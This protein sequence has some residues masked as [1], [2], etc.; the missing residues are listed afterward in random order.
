MRFI[1]SAFAVLIIAFL[2]LPFFA[3]RVSAEKVDEYP[4]AKFIINQKT[5]HSADIINATGS[6]NANRTLANLQE[7]YEEAIEINEDFD[8]INIVVTN[9]ATIS[10]K[11]IDRIAA[12]ADQKDID[13]VLCADNME[14]K[15]VAS[16]LIIDVN[17]YEKT[18]KGLY[19]TSVLLTDSEIE[20]LLGKSAENNLTV[21][22]LTQTGNLAAPI[23]I[24]VKLDIEN[25]ETLDV[26]YSFDPKTN[27]YKAIRTSFAVD[28]NG[29]AHFDVTTGGYIVVAAMGVIE[30]PAPSTAE[31]TEISLSFTDFAVFDGIIYSNIS[32]ERSWVEAGY[33][34][35]KGEFFDEVQANSDNRIL[36]EIESGTANLMPVGTK[37]YKCTNHFDIILADTPDGMIP[38]LK[39]VEG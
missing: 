14:G 10:Y 37:F 13:V 21:L 34:Y 9:A 2:V 11:T 19:L 7:V 27:E 22:D 3:L 8:K 38:F 23:E 30:T 35:I 5:V 36:A 32:K 28:K 18:N 29:Y 4:L 24:A 25:P 1:L 26:Y 31:I 20:T 33:E 6:I 12:F 16:R 17:E 15:K 39:I